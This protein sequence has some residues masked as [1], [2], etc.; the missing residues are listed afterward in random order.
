MYHWLCGNDLLKENEGIHTISYHN[1][2]MVM[3]NCEIT[4]SLLNRVFASFNETK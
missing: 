1:C 2:N 3:Y 4:S